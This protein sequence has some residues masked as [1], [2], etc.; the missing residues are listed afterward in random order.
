MGRSGWQLETQQK[1]FDLVEALLTWADR[2]IENGV[3]P[4]Y[5]IE[6]EW[7]TQSSNDFWLRVKMTD[8]DLNQLF[9]LFCEQ[10]RGKKINSEKRDLK[11]LLE[12]LEE[13]KLL[14]PIN[15]GDYNLPR[16]PGKLFYL[17]LPS[18]NRFTNLKHVRSLIA[19]QG[20]STQVQQASGIE[21]QV[22]QVRQHLYEKI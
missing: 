16:V 10:E 4:P 5:A 12:K 3:E 17:K 19:A 21:A 15:D 11:Y 13:I 22:Q 6:F 20:S 14:D 8:K 18:K 7:V 9:I 1:V 2:K